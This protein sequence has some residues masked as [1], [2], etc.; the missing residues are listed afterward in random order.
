MARSR[1]VER[2]DVRDLRSRAEPAAAAATAATAQPDMLAPAEDGAAPRSELGAGD[3]VL[4]RPVVGTK[5]GTA[6]SPTAA[7]AAIPAQLE[8][9]DDMVYFYTGR[10]K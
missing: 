6:H 5:A 2:C 8:R 7:A 10:M 1:R 9:A 4:S 3:P